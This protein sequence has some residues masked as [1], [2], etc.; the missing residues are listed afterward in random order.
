[1]NIQR[2]IILVLCV[3]LVAIFSLLITGC[4]SRPSYQQYPRVIREQP[5][6]RPKPPPGFNVAIKI[7]EWTVIDHIILDYNSK[8]GYIRFAGRFNYGGELVFKFKSS[9][10]PDH[11]WLVKIPSVRKGIYEIRTKLYEEPTPWPAIEPPKRFS[12][13]IKIK[14]GKISDHFIND[15]HPGWG[16]FVFSRFNKGIIYLRNPFYPGHE[17]GARIPKRNG[18]W[19]I[20]PNL[21]TR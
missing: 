13:V 1:M 14:N 5:L 20:Y 16:E 12:V 2:N 19:T 8:W 9:Q 15:P 4:V 11:Y 3:S 18:K 17:W 21:I 7:K 10:F 6:Q